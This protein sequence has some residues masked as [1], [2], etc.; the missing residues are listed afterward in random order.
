MDELR[1]A[2]HVEL[3]GLEEREEQE[4]REGEEQ[5]EEGEEDN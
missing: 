5:E 4:E 1:Q 2:V 3:W